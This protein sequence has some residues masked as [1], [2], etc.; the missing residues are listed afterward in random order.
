MHRGRVHLL[1]GPD[2]ADMLCDQGSDLRME[3]VNTARDVPPH[4]LGLGSL[5]PPYTSVRGAFTA[6]RL[7][8]KVNTVVLC[9]REGENGGRSNRDGWRH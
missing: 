8:V 9:N 1:H 6:S 2:I 3:P 5:G 4:S 7:C